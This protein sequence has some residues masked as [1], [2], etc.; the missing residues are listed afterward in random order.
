MDAQR[1][2]SALECVCLRLKM[3]CM[4]GLVEP[5]KRWIK[6]TREVAENAVRQAKEAAK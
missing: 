6:D 1:L 3:F 2:V 5:Q 4:D